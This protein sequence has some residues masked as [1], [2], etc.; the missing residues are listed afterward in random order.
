MGDHAVQ[1]SPNTHT[2]H[3]TTTVYFLTLKKGAGRQYNLKKALL[4]WFPEDDEQGISIDTISDDEYVITNSNTQTAEIRFNNGST[5]TAYIYSAGTVLSMLENLRLF[6]R[7]SSG[8]T[9]EMAAH[10]RRNINDANNQR[11]AHRAPHV[12][13]SHDSSAP[14]SSSRPQAPSS[15]SLY[16][17]P[18]SASQPDRHASSTSQPDQRTSSAFQPSRK[19]Q[20]SDPGCVQ[21]GNQRAR[22]ETE[23]VGLVE[24][25]RMH[26]NQTP[27]TYV[28]LAT[29]V[30]EYVRML[31]PDDANTPHLAY[32]LTDS[33]KYRDTQGIH[34][35]FVC[36]FTRITTKLANA[37]RHDVQTVTVFRVGANDNSIRTYAKKFAALFALSGEER[38]SVAITHSNMGKFFQHMAIVL[39]I[40]GCSDELVN[41]FMGIVNPTRYL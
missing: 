33:W 35:S 27:Q 28:D 11:L 26:S 15:S 32:Y 14:S 34:P 36:L 22:I 7:M 12:D 39:K 8:V 31:G 19:R 10:H 24:N 16:Q 13:L 9:P 25:P 30:D 17:A 3:Y 2:S 1:G 21:G 18:S 37:L 23:D 5:A 29:R 6:Q 4:R 40:V 38:S 41:M 20:R